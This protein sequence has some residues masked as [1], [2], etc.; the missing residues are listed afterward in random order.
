MIVRMQG[1][2]AVAEKCLRAADRRVEELQAM[3]TIMRKEMV[4]LEAMLEQKSQAKDEQ[5]TKLQER[6]ADAG[7]GNERLKGKLNVS[8]L[9]HQRALLQNKDLMV[10]LSKAEAQNEGLKN[11]E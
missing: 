2:E 5:R 6:I 11:I 10:A 4:R 1:K 7:R 3:I 8:R 9:Q